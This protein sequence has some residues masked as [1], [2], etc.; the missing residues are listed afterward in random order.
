MA[1]LRAMGCLMNI[2]R[3]TQPTIRA[4][5]IAC[6][7]GL[8]PLSATAAALSATAAVLSATPATIAPQAVNAGGAAPSVDDA[9]VAT[10][11]A[12]D[13]PVTAVTLYRSAAMIT[14][15][16][17]LPEG[18]GQGQGTF[19]LRIEGLPESI[20]GESLSA[21]VTGAKLLDVRF[22]TKVT[23][24][25]AA[26]N[27]E[28]RNAIAMLEQTK[29]AG[30]ALALHSARLADQN[31][32][33][34]AIAAKTATESAQDFGSKS[35]DPEAL[36]RQVAFLNEARKALIDERTE[37]DA[38]IRVNA[39]ENA[40]LADRVKQLGGQSTVVRAAVVAVGKSQPGPGSVAIQYLVGA[41]RWS[42]DYAIRARDTGDDARDAL[43]VEFNAV[44]AQSTGTDWNDV[45]VTLSTAEPERRPAP[46]E[47]DPEYLSVR[48]PAM[49]KDAGAVR[50]GFA[51]G[52]GA[53]NMA[54][55]S[56]VPL[57]GTGGVIGD[58]GNLGDAEAISLGL[59]LDRAYADAE[60]AGGAVVSYQLPRR[61]GI[62][63]DASRTRTQRIAT[64]ELD[65]EF[66]HVAR[67]IVDPT[68]YLR[69]K[70]RNTSSYRLIAG[71]ARLFVGDDSVGEAELPDIIPGA[72]VNFW[73]GGDPRIES[74]RVLVSQQTR[75]E[76][77]FGKSRV[78]TSSWRID[79]TSAAP[80]T[81]R[82][83]LSDR[84][85]VSRDEKVKVELRDLSTPLSTD[86][87]Y[88]ANERTRGILRWVLDM[89]GLGKDG[90]PSRL[91]ISWTVR[92]S[93]AIEVEVERGG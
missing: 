56:P 36:A 5:A 59:K 57:A 12:V 43:T 15:T 93:H 17:A 10:T 18:A 90:K 14:H 72:E 21:R 3:R 80:G 32:L 29:R 22:E 24:V 6:L 60:A 82:V 76:G 87:E 33:L 83:E 26:T 55:G 53:P 42:P 81:S 45:S 61:V 50:Y 52:G 9:P 51:G 34:S 2:T 75:E 77:V 23:P 31:A 19:E 67:P 68:V 71:P 7:L 11:L 91:G 35:L 62:P 30:E 79:L 86:A 88:L 47:I 39:M 92:E 66:S 37:L 28:L 70:A 27:P 25:D 41:A 63:S 89:P 48:E 46:P 4:A 8:A 58:P 65:P 69:A 73:L 1:I 85:P 13:A 16:A 40:A 74:K 49:D 64:I 38:R 84:I 44:I 54:P 78:T 20:D